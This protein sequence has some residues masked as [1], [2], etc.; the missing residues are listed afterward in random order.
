MGRARIAAVR[1]GYD[2]FAKG[3]IET[4][5]ALF[6]PNATWHSVE[7]GILPGSYRGA[8]A[9]LEF[10]GR[11][12]HETNGT[13]RAELQTTAASGDHV[14]ALHRNTGKRK[15][16]TEDTKAVLVFKLDKALVTEM[17]E[18][19]FDHPADAQFWS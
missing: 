16:K 2:A 15:G 12:G 4:L 9:I 6:A 14:F 10:F 7:I 11:L 3:D 1:R 18:F 13:V 17:A 5:K 19:R 8:Q